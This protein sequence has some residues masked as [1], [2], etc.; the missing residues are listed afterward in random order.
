MVKAVSHSIHAE[1]ISNRPVSP[2]HFILRLDAPEIVQS[3]RPGQFAMIRPLPGSTDPLLGRPLAIFDAD[4]AEGS[5]AFLYIPI[6]KGTTLLSNLRPGDKVAINGPLGKGFDLAGEEK[7]VG[8]AGGTGVAAVHFLLKKGR[9]AGRNTALYLGARTQ[10]LLVPEDVFS[11]GGEYVCATDDGSCGFS[12]TV[13]DGMRQQLDAGVLGDGERYY[14]A[15]PVPMMA[16]AAAL[17]E[18]KGLWMEVSLEARMGCGVGACRGC[19]VPARTPHRLYGFMHR[20]V[21]S[22]GPVFRPEEIDWA[23]L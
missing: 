2:K 19:I 13:I 7:A 23:G 15:G 21:C 9:E 4:E 6:G 18:E 17:A 22:D 8:I 20:A 5:A 10:A 12:G 16:A 11:F 3:V 14:V 1:V